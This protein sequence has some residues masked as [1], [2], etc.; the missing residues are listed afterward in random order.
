MEAQWCWLVAG[1]FR[2]IQKVQHDDD[3]DDEI[4][5]GGDEAPARGNI[6]RTY[7]VSNWNDIAVESSQGERE[8][9]TTRQPSDARNRRSQHN[10]HE[11]AVEVERSL[12]S[13]PH[14]KGSNSQPSTQDDADA[15]AAAATADG[16]G[17]GEGQRK[18]CWALLN[19]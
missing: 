3:R 17:E 5:R 7:S 10:H 14:G 18:S 4:L 6:L 12:H 19:N 11:P 13:L 9:I 15:A 16:T 1:L 8:G 2:S